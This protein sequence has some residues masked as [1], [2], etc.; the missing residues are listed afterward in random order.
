M[1]EHA[2][3]LG[4]ERNTIIKQ[5]EAIAFKQLFACIYAI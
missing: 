4:L 2:M 5:F 1:G 3:Q